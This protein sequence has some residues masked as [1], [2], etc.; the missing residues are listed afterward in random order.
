M[1]RLSSKARFAL[2]CDDSS[3]EHPNCFVALLNL[4]ITDSRLSLE[5]FG[6]AVPLLFAET[7]R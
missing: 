7:L 4:S 2:L 6:I 3:I 5:S 1:L